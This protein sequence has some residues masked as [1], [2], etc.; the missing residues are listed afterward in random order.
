MMDRF[1][2]LTSVRHDE[3]ILVNVNHISMVLPNRIG[4]QIVIDQD[5][6]RPVPVVESY[7]KL[8]ELLVI[9]TG[10]GGE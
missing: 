6:A 9:K 2:E 10:K 7:E 4:S 8:K 1:I 3:P 5:D